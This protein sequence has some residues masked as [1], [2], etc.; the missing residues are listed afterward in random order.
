MLHHEKK[1]LSETKDSEIY[2]KWKIQTVLLKSASQRMQL[3]NSDPC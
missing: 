3:Q 2:S 1:Q